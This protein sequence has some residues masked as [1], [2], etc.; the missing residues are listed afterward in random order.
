V[1]GSL[2]GS[3]RGSGGDDEFYSSGYS[4]VE[5]V[6]VSVKQ[7]NLSVGWCWSECHYYDPK[8]SSDVCQSNPDQHALVSLTLSP[9]GT[10]ACLRSTNRSLMGEHLGGTLE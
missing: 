10:D 7:M 2:S 9:A 5:R 3:E 1:S 6:K 4:E 8:V